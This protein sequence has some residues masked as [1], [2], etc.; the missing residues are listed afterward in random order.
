MLRVILLLLHPASSDLHPDIILKD[1]FVCLGIHLP[2]N[3]GILMCPGPE[4]AKLVHSAPSVLL[5][6]F[7]SFLTLY[8]VVHILF[9][10]LCQM[11][12]LGMRTIQYMC[13]ISSYLLIFDYLFGVEYFLYQHIC[14]Q[15]KQKTK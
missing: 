14:Q 15:N 1:T 13:V 12:S 9:H 4:A 6:L 11:Y 3:D 10:T 7:V 8:W 5:L 2:N